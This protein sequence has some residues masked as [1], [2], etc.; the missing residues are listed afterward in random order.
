MKSIQKDSS[1]VALEVYTGMDGPSRLSIRSGLDYC[2]S[3]IQFV[4]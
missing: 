3:M 2:F 4:L 1:C